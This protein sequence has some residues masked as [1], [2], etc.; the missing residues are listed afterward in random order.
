MDKKSDQQRY[1]TNWIVRFL[2]DCKNLN[3]EINIHKGI[4]QEISTHGMRI[5]SDHQICDQKLIAMQL[6]IPSLLNNAPFKIVKII[7]NSIDTIKKEGKFQTE[8]EFKHF[9]ENGMKE[10]EKNLFQLFKQPFFSQ[11]AQHA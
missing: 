1:P 3:K 8:I 7:G 5:L 4:A 11:T 9:E 6:M 2:C 10:L